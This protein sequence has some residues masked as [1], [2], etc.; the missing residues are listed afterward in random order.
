MRGL[1]HARSTGRAHRYFCREEAFLKLRNTMTLF[2]VSLALSVVIL[3]GNPPGSTSGVVQSAVDSV[4]NDYPYLLSIEKSVPGSPDP[5]AAAA[6]GSRDEALASPADAQRVYSL[7]TVQAAT[8]N[9]DLPEHEFWRLADRNR[10]AMY[11]VLWRILDDGD[12]ENAELRNFVL[13]TLDGRFDS[14]PGGMYSVL[15]RTAPTPALRKE[16]LQLLAEASQE[17]SVRALGQALDHPDS[18]VRQSAA[19]SLDGLGVDAL[20]DAMGDAVLDS[21]HSVR[22]TAFQTL[23]DMHGFAPI[24]I[25]AERIVGNPDPDIRRRALELITYGDT[26]NALDHLTRSL[27]DPDPRVSELAVALLAEYEEGST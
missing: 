8:V 12:D 13:D 22:L 26:E 25:V 24:W 6:A 14:T 18:A 17:L 7:A 21:D 4:P 2:L 3:A 15:I 20:L 16:I 27:L 9:A 23:E 10:E 5:A 19:A 1:D 11:A